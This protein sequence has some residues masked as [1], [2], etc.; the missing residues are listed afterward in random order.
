M[1]DLSISKYPEVWGSLEAFAEDHTLLDASFLA[2]YAEYSP[3]TTSPGSSSSSA[4]TINTPQSGSTGLHSAG[5]R[6]NGRHESIPPERR[7]YFPE[8]SPSDH[9]VFPGSSENANGGDADA[10]VLRESL[11]PRGINC[12]LGEQSSI[13]QLG[14]QFHGTFPGNFITIFSDR[15]D[16]E[17]P[18]SQLG[19]LIPDDGLS[20]LQHF[21]HEPNEQHYQ[22][23]AP[24]ACL[25]Q[26]ASQHT[27]SWEQFALDQTTVGP[28][29]YEQR[30]G[31]LYELPS[32]SDWIS[33]MPNMPNN[34]GFPLSPQHQASFSFHTPEE[35]QLAVSSSMGASLSIGLGYDV[36]D[37]S[38]ILE[39]SSSN[40]CRTKE[41]PATTFQDS[42]SQSES[43]QRPHTERESSSPIRTKGISPTAQRGSSRNVNNPGPLSQ[44]RRPKQR[45]AFTDPVERMETGKTR[46]SRA[47][48]RCRMQRI[49][50]RPSNSWSRA[51]LTSITKSVPHRPSQCSWH[52]YHLPRHNQSHTVKTPLP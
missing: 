25:T 1:S 28:P 23:S 21:N 27:Q 30:N 26:D 46:K 18:S 6:S 24:Q 45:G 15:N 29:T 9:D 34:P 13:A 47:C 20:C 43:I 5:I 48:L 40:L 16:S 22:Y 32:P 17:A 44:R 38:E 35:P 52:V 41:T 19:A 49:R 33:N 7:E 4:T 50:V 10:E 8:H 42:Q 51:Q 39:G 12:Q 3:G 11:A 36:N 14:H 37:D 2:N 31:Y